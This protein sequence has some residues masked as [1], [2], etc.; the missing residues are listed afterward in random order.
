[1]TPS[2]EPHVRLLI[3]EDNAPIRGLLIALL[4][5]AE[6]IMQGM[7]IQFSLEY[8]QCGNGQAAIQAIESENTLDGL[9]T[10]FD[11]GRGPTGKD[12]IEAYIKKFP[13]GNIILYTSQAK[14]SI[15]VASCLRLSPKV[16]YILKS[17]T[18]ELVD[19]LPLFLRGVS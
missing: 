10:D 3:A 18:Q 17:S 4:R 11:L 5:N 13:E 6:S 7:G 8:I 9:I 15:Y 14:E 2:G 16:R 19:Q 1:M 12:I